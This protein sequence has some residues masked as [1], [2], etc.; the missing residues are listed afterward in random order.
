[1]LS[2]EQVFE[3]VGAVVAQR[4]HDHDGSLAR[5]VP[6]LLLQMRSDRRQTRNVGGIL[7]GV[8]RAEALVQTIGIAGIGPISDFPDSREDLFHGSI[9]Q[10][11]MLSVHNRC[12]LDIEPDES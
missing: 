8:E 6:D 4:I 3:C 9:T 2:N 10:L 7:E 12:L 11:Q 5:T 1:M